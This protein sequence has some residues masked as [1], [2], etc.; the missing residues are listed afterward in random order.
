MTRDKA[1]P[2]HNPLKDTCP[3]SAAELMV[4]FSCSFTLVR[5]TCFRMC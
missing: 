1:L 4:F 2:S 5:I 3:E